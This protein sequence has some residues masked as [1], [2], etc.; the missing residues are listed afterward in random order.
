MPNRFF[1]QPLILLFLFSECLF[2][3]LQAQ[4][5]GFELPRGKMSDF[6]FELH[7]NFIVVDILFNQALPVKF[8]L[9]T[10][11]EHTLLLKREFSDLMGVQYLRTFKI[12][13]TDAK[14]ELTAYIAKNISLKIQ[15]SRIEAPHQDILVLEEDYFKLDESIGIPIVGILGGDMLRNLIV[16]IDYQHQRVRLYPPDKFTIPKETTTHPINFVHG[17]PYLQTT[18]FVEPNKPIATEYLL[19]TGASLTMLINNDTDPSLALP[20]DVI[21]GPL[22]TGLGGIVEGYVG[23]IHQLTFGDYHFDNVIANFQAIGE[24]VVVKEKKRNGII[25]ALLLFRFTV[26]IDYVNQKLYLRPNRYF[27]QTFHYDRSGLI[28]ISSGQNLNVFSIHGVV[29][30][31]PAAEADFRKGDKIR[32]INHINTNWLSLE[33]IGSILQGKVNRKVRVVI[34]REKKRLIKEIRLRDLI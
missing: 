15:N 8:I 32:S 31:S 33:G 14:R 25:G 1:S 18:T 5:L 2:C 17:K 21:S 24:N 16:Q 26:T 4:S 7:N 34:F 3:N 13:G 22:G 30:N 6:S 12:Y 19:D 10:G 9:D 29:Q 28:I 27:K 20:S 11:A 23:R